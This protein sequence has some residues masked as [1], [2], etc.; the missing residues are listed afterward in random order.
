MPESKSTEQQNKKKT[1][2]NSDRGTTLAHYQIA[3]ALLKRDL[4][5]GPI[6]ITE[7]YWENL[8]VDASLILNQVRKL[9]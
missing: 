1:L 5:K 6:S 9:K 4:S 2:T 3:E 8:L 7:T